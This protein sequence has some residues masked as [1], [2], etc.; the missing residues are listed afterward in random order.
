ME[1]I[2]EALAVAATHDL[3]WE[4]KVKAIEFWH[5]VIKR[6]L[7][8]QGVIDGTFPSVTFSKEN[9]KIVTLTQKEITLRLTKV[10]VQLSKFGC[11]GVLLAS[12]EDQDDVLV[13]KK[14]VDVIKSLTEFLDRYNYW[15]EVRDHHHNTVLSLSNE[16]SNSWVMKHEKCSNVSLNEKCSSNGANHSK[17]E[18]L[19]SDDV[20]QSI[21][22][23]QD[24]N[25]LSKAYE[26]QMNVDADKCRNEENECRTEENAEYFKCF[27]QITPE[28]FLDT[29]KKTDVNQLLQTKTEWMAHTESFSSLLNDM[30]YSLQAHELHDADCY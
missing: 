19:N 14:G 12:L 13:V 22:S 24:I 10:L 18:Q 16:L 7:Q 4:V 30:S 1:S 5:Y 6:Q 9:K 3:F 15:G 20:I 23:A 2:Y 21:I 27:R 11:L 17:S 26:N 8:Y 29:I 28:I 25:L